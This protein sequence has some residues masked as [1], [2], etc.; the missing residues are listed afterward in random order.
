MNVYRQELRMLR[1]SFIV[2]TASV[3]AL[4]TLYLTVYPAFAK[5][6][7]SLQQIIAHFPAA[8]KSAMGAGLFDMFTFV[9]FFANISFVFMLAFAIQAM[10]IG[11]SMT[12]REALA[13]TTDFLLTKPL[14]RSRIFS[15]KLLASLTVLFATSVIF[16]LY[17]FVGAKIAGAG[18]FD[19]KAFFMIY[20][21]LAGLQLWF[22]G[23]GTV[24]AQLRRRVRSV[25]SLSLGIVLALFVLGLFGGLTDDKLVRYVSPFKYIDLIKVI[26]HGQYETPYV[27]LWAAIVVLSLGAGWLLY[28]KRDVPAQV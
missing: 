16:I 24:V 19:H 9:G 28:K 13:R 3:L 11:I 18:A 23:V 27:V 26:Q 5:D 6:A 10:N 14:T 7:D 1:G 25:I 20:G 22:L 17:F 15:Q 4:A 12:N 2:W 8:V 21:V